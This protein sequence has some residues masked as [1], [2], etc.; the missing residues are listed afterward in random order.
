[1]PVMSMLSLLSFL[2]VSMQAQACPVLP[3]KPDHLLAKHAE[4]QHASRN[5]K[6]ENPKLTI[7]L[8]ARL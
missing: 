8:M 7:L 4:P 5:F 6:H 1:M 3:V 2:R